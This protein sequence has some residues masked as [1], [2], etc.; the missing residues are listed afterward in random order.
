MII[1]IEIISNTI[2]KD[3]KETT[4]LTNSLYARIIDIPCRIF[5]ELLN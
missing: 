4:N 2:V 3:L 1:L 5:I